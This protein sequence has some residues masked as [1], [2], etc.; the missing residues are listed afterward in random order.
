METH[1]RWKDGRTVFAVVALQETQRQLRRYR[2][3]LQ[4]EYSCHS[5]PHFP[6]LAL[7]I[8]E[9]RRVIP[10][11]HVDRFCRTT[12][13][14]AQWARSILCE[15]DRQRDC[16]ARHAR[17]NNLAMRQIVSQSLARSDSGR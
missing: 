9:K 17:D 15:P 13:C 11:R 12:T 16:A 14:R 10:Y 5:L 2:H 6:V 3:G 4:S 1:G 8:S 7:A